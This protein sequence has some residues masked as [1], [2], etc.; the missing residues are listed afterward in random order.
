MMKKQIKELSNHTDLWPWYWY[1][2]GEQCYAFAVV[3][4]YPLKHGDPFPEPGSELAFTED[5]KNKY[6]WTGEN[7]TKMIIETEISNI[8]QQN[9]DA[10]CSFIAAAHAKLMKDHI[11]TDFEA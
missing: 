4:A 2:Y 10:I 9:G 5:E 6:W 11:C 1:A 8:Q 7:G 3:E